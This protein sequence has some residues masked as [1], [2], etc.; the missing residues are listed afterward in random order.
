M[1]F[2]QQNLIDLSPCHDGLAFARLH[3]FDWQKVWDKCERGDW[4]IW[5][6]RKTGQMD[7]PMAV[8]I[9]IACAE[10]LLPKFEAKYPADD[11]PRKAIESAKNWLANPSA[12]ASVASAS[13]GPGRDGGDPRR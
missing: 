11:R 8:K 9:A 1:K 5:W 3:K 10:N 13:A 4:L 2:T 12:S 6:L 7:K